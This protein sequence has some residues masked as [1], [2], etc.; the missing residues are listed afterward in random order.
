MG[1]SSSLENQPLFRC[2]SASSPGFSG[3]GVSGAALLGGSAPCGGFA[4][5]ALGGVGVS[6]RFVGSAFS[7]GLAGFAFSAPFPALVDGL[8]RARA[9]GFDLALAAGALSSADGASASASPPCAH[10]QL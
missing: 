3:G 6:V 5:T 2:L 8:R 10:H 1:Q 7:I 9:R 4:S